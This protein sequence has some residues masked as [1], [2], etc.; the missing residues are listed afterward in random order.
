MLPLNF[1][2]ACRLL[3][4]ALGDRPLL[5]DFHRVPPLN[6][7]RAEYHTRPVHFTKMAQRYDCVHDLPLDTGCISNQ[8]EPRRRKLKNI[9]NIQKNLT[10]VT[11]IMHCIQIPE[12]EKKGNSMKYGK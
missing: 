1:R 5:H 9:A 8:P 10:C 4:A 7:L 2:A 6:R 12:Q 11:I 3:T